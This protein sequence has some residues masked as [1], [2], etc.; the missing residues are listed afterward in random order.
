MNST[1]ESEK[2]TSAPEVPQPKTKRTPAK[3]AK[4]AKKAARTGK[5]AT[6]QPAAIAGLGQPLK[7]GLLEPRPQATSSESN[8]REE[9]CGDPALGCSGEGGRSI[10]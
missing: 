9:I 5:P 6:M 10:A 4:P 2:N 3:K 8:F 7:A 1:T